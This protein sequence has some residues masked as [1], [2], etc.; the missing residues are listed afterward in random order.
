[1][2][3]NL[4]GAEV[5]V[6]CAVKDTRIGHIDAERTAQGSAALFHIGGMAL[7]QKHHGEAAEASLIICVYVMHI[8]LLA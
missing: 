2:N 3:F 7:A 4:A 6:D 5:I 1:M 8:I